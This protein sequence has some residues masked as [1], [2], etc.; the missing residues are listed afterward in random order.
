MTNNCLLKY[1]SVHF[2]DLETSEIHPADIFNVNRVCHIRRKKNYIQCRTRN[3]KRRPSR[4][5]VARVTPQITPANDLFV[6]F[7]AESMHINMACDCIH[8]K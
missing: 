8:S 4:T 5:E 3:W 6:A 1:R 2:L 7:V